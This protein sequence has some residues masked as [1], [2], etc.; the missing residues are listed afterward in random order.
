[1]NVS[2]A[3]NICT[4]WYEARDGFMLLSDRFEPEKLEI[5]IKARKGY[6]RELNHELEAVTRIALSSGV[7]TDY[8]GSYWVIRQ[9]GQLF[10]LSHEE[11]ESI[12]KNTKEENVAYD[13][14]FNLHGVR[15]YASAVFSNKG[16]LVGILALAETFSPLHM[17]AHP[18]IIEQIKQFSKN[19]SIRLE[20]M[21]IS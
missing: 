20:S 10:C 17:K 14:F 6:R 5:S 4:E 8:K 21:E 7:H 15:R 12:L 2:N 16:E 11:Q 19:I 13:E 3:L 18:E 1:M 9:N